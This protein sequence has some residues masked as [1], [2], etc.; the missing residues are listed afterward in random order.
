MTRALA[1]IILALAALAA[2]PQLETPDEPTVFLDFGFAGE[3]TAGGWC[4]VSASVQAVDDPLSGYIELTYVA[5]GET[6]AHVAPFAV[7]ARDNASIPMTIYLPWWT[8]SITVAAYD[9]RQGRVAEIRYLSRPGPNDARLPATSRATG[10]VLSV[11]PRLPAGVAIDKA[12]PAEAKPLDLLALNIT[13]D[14]LHPSRLAYDNVSLLI[15]DPANLGAADPRAVESVIR[16]TASGGRLLLIIERPGAEWQRILNV[17]PAT[18]DITLGA[19]AIGDNS[20]IRPIVVGPLAKACGWKIDHTSEGGPVAAQG[21]FGLGTLAILSTDPSADITPSLIKDMLTTLTPSAMHD[22]TAAIRDTEQHWY[23]VYNSRGN[24]W[25]LYQHIDAVASAEPPGTGGFILIAV[26]PLALA[27]LL[28]PIDYILLGRLRRRPLAWLSALVWIGALGTISLIAP[29]LFQTG[30]ADIGSVAAIDII[31]P[32]LAM[33]AAR[34]INRAAALD[35]A[36][37]GWSAGA[38]ILF[39]A[40]REPFT[41]AGDAPDAWRPFESGNAD[42]VAL[43]GTVFRQSPAGPSTQAAA[44]V[45][46]VRIPPRIWS[47]ATLHREGPRRPPFAVAL[48]ANNPNAPRELTLDIKGLPESATIHAARIVHDGSEF[49]LASAAESPL[50]F[51]VGSRGTQFGT[52]GMHARQMLAAIALLAG[53]PERRNRAIVALTN[54]GWARIDLF[55]ETPPDP[56]AFQTE[57]EAVTTSYALY[58]ILTPM[59]E[60][61]P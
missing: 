15:I 39:H 43:T 4:P 6:I 2:R 18:A 31:T 8:E 44:A 46:P 53:E 7:A 11:T 26:V 58:R 45:T 48:T 56:A 42:V 61:Q 1:A 32:N 3:L 12:Q 17:T 21:P 9:E 35:P 14:R 38:S 33:P 47:L 52:Q 60:Q 29:R 20:V 27:L 51:T 37:A 22:L 19:V 49:M 34:G 41:L 30:N 23:D 59:P 36:L 28:G 10:V 50:R 13:P 16:W 25:L 54:A 55:I 5:G 24:D 57:D 40:S